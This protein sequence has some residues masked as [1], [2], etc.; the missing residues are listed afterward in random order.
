MNRFLAATAPCLVALAC[1]VPIDVLAQRAEMP[2]IVA[3]SPRSVARLAA[4]PAITAAA[5]A[6]LV[7]EVDDDAHGAFKEGTFATCSVAGVCTVAFTA[8]PAGHRRL[9]QHLTCSIYVATTG[10]LRYVA[11]LANSF[12][13]PREFAPY[14]RSAADA[15]QYF[16]DVATAFPFDA[17]ETPLV[18]AYA[19]TSPIQDL[20]CTIMG[21]DIVLP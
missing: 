3:A 1:A 5:R 10:A 13:A 12:T 9:V 2:P 11:F 14:T 8:V 19:D 20:T 15:G 18:Y 6:A 4:S 17:G 21:R 7:Q 16:V